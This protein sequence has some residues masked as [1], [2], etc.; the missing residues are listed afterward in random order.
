MTNYVSR[1]I[2]NYSTT[3]EPLRA[4]LKKDAEW[5]R[6]YEQQQAFD[7]LKSDFSSETVMKYFDPNKETK[8]IVDASPVGL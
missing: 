6:N 4:L 3:T 5:Q 1:Y 2:P 8:I 7:Q